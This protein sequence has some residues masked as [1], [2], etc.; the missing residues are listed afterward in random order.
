MRLIRLPL[1]LGALVLAAPTTA[2]AVAPTLSTVTTLS[3]AVSPAGEGDPITLTAVVDGPGWP[4]GSVTFSDYELGALQSAPVQAGKATAVLPPMAPGLHLLS[5]DYSGDGYFAPSAARLTQRVGPPVSST[6]V[7][8][9]DHNPTSPG[10]G[11]TLTASLQSSS[12]YG[13]A[14]GTVTL[15]EGGNQMATLP[16]SLLA[17]PAGRGGT[18][19]Q[20]SFAAALPAGVHSITA[21]YSGDGNLSGGSSTTWT[22]VVGERVATTTTLVPPANPSLGGQPATLTATVAPSTPASKL[23]SGTLTF[24]DGGTV[25]GRAS[26]AAGAGSLAVSLLDAGAHA[27][28]VAYSGDGDFLASTSAPL[29]LQILGVGG[30][31]TPT[32]T[33]LAAG[34]NPVSFGQPVTFKVSVAAVSRTESPGGSVYFADES[35]SVLGSATLDSSGQALLTTSTVSPGPHRIKAV[36]AGGN[37]FAHSSSDVFELSVERAQASIS[38]LSGAS[39]SGAQVVS[40]GVAVS[41]QPGAP[42]AGSVT[43]VEQGAVIGTV[44]VGDQGRAQLDL[45][46]LAAG[47]HRVIAVY[48]GDG[49]YAS[50]SA[51]F[52]VLVPGPVATGTSVKANQSRVLPSRDLTLTATVA[53]TSPAGETPAGSITFKEGD[54][55]LGTGP[56]D[57]QGSAVLELPALSPGTH[58]IVASFPGSGSLGPSTGT[59]TVQVLTTDDP[60]SEGG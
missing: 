45:A 59:V 55:V 48:N 44:S 51:S 33:A 60:A 50:V 19:D 37:R 35:G 38:A 29:A 24:R 32:A 15:M 46:G 40:A 1:L 16:L 3:S 27:L 47:L 20:V 39:P 25:L 56:L 17:A 26:L 22:E 8:G 53:A 54:E 42:P 28:T 6:V 14:S 18:P 7:I 36:Y 13:M 49:N 10:Q 12:G 41:G 21:V 34:P 9:A 5:A 43:F 2:Y 11:V 30:G 52:T 31:P 23:P 4:G 57:G 58:T